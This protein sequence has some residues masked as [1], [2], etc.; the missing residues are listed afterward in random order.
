M[1]RRNFIKA[2][3]CGVASTVLSGC[4]GYLRKHKNTRAEDRPNFII[5]LCDDLGYGDLGCYGHPYIKT[6]NIDKL[7]KEGMKLTDCYAAASM[8]G[9]LR[10]VLYIYRAKR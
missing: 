5:V 6:P 3:G 9:F 8:T 10:A 7:A 1:N 2:V 4:V